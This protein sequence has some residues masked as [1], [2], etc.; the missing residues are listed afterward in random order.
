MAL[1]FK[2]KTVRTSQS[3]ANEKELFD[4]IKD[5]AIT[6]AKPFLFISD[7]RTEKLII[8]PY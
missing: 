2:L 7:C 1:G 8:E 4:R 6:S 3:F 5:E